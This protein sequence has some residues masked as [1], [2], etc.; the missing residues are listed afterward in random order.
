MNDAAFVSGIEI[1][2]FAQFLLLPALRLPKLADSLSQLNTHL[3]HHCLRCSTK[4]LHRG[5]TPQTMSI[6]LR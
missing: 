4:S 6:T 1:R 2:T 3:L 5:T